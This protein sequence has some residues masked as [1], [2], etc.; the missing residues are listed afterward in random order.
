MITGDAGRAWGKVIPLKPLT[1]E[2]HTPP[3]TNLSA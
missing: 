3:R 2:I 1:D